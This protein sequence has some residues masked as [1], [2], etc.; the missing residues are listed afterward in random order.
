MRR[1]AR[2]WS[3]F[4]KASPPL[5]SFHHCFRHSFNPETGS[6]QGEMMQFSDQPSVVGIM[7]VEGYH[8]GAIRELLI[9]QAYDT[10]VHDNMLVTNLTAV[11]AESDRVRFTANYKVEARVWVRL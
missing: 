3:A 1:Q 10:V 6:A 4:G 9:R 5:P 11:R 7:A 8:A 2:P